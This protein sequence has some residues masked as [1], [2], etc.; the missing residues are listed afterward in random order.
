[1]DSTYYRL[2]ETEGREPVSRDV[3]SERQP[4]LPDIWLNSSLAM[5][6][7]FQCV[8]VQEGY[9]RWAQTYDNTPNP[10]LALEERHLIPFLPDLDGKRVLDL[11]CG[12][13]RWLARLL[14]RGASAGVGV[15]VSASMLRVAATK[16]AITGRLVLADCLQLPLRPNVF[17]FVLC[18]FALNHIPKL[19]VMARELARVMRSEGQILI[20]ELHPEAYTR[21]WRPGFR[22]LR[23]AVQVESMP[24]SSEHVVECFQS[25][26]FACMKL[27]T[28]FFGE[29]ERTIFLERG[30]EK[31]FEYACRVP[32]VQIYHF[33]KFDSASG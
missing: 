30:K 22:D 26:F 31:I 15:D 11:A 12:T 33:R 14:A 5:P 28:F 17:D 4:C 6:P 9:E 29:P 32:A 3:S 13:G 8:S 25:H 7:E 18:S 1:V 2:A 19:G 21:G 10:L 24:R 20:S 23:S 27:Y 16:S